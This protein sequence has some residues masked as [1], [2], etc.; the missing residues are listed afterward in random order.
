MTVDK[1]DQTVK[2]CTAGGGKVL[3]PPMDIA[4]V[5]RFAV[6]QTPD[7]VTFSAITWAS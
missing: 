5:G 3:V 4:K 6:M 2:D 7:G 1:V